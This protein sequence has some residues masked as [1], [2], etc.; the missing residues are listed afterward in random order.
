MLMEMVNKRRAAAGLNAVPGTVG[1]GLPVN[2]I[3]PKWV[4]LPIEAVERGLVRYRSSTSKIY[5]SE[6]SVKKFDN[7]NLMKFIQLKQRGSDG[8]KSTS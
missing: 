5:A 4:G 8:T 1:V 7:D 2:S 6:E 3:T